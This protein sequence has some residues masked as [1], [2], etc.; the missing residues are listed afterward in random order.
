MARSGKASLWRAELAEHPDERAQLVVLRQPR[1]H[2]HSAVAVVVDGGGR[3][4][5]DGAG[6]HRLL[7]DRAHGG[8]FALGRRTLRGLGPQYGGAHRRMADEDAGVG[9]ASLAPQQ[10]QIVGEPLEAPVDPGFERGDGHALDLGQVASHLLAPL[11]R[12]GRD[13][14]AAIAHDNGGDA[15]RRRRRR[16]AL[17]GELR[18]VVGMHVDD[19]RCQHEAVR[20]HRLPCALRHI[21][22][23]GDT[24]ATDGDIS[25]HERVAQAVRDRRPSNC[26][27]MYNLNRCLPR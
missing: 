10:R 24:L 4:E 2:R 20:L 7:H 1:G 17:P 14:E 16:P 12:T 22:D 25:T 23:L 19:A 18:V 11:W 5:A 6:L 13:A 15:E 9:I 27:I 26:E 3:G 21:A 8:D